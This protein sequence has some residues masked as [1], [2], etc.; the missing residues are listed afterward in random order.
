[1][2]KAFLVKPLSHDRIRDLSFVALSDD[3]YRLQDFF[4]GCVGFKKVRFGNREFTLGTDNYSKN[5]HALLTVLRKTEKLVLQ[6]LEKTFVILEVM[7]EN[8][9]MLRNIRSISIEYFSDYDSYA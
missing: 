3:L 1:M 2:T 4:D 5:K 6:R 8:A 9:E 7:E